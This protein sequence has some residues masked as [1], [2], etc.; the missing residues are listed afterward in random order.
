M[1]IYEQS[2]GW[3]C[4]GF[5]FTQKSVESMQFFKCVW[6]LL[7]SFCPCVQAKEGNLFLKPSSQITSYIIDQPVIDKVAYSF[8]ER[9]FW[10]NYG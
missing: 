9:D 10:L 8:S 3:V 4:F 1:N 5:F 2:K 6:I 7:I